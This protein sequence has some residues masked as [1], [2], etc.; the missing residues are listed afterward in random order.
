[1]KQ[2]AFLILL[3]FLILMP[4]GGFGFSKET[5]ETASGSPDLSKLSVLDLKTAGKIALS[6][7]PSL[8]AARSRVQQAKARLSQTRSAYWP[9]LDATA[10]YSRIDLSGRTYA[11]NLAFARIFDPAA[12]VDNPDDYYNAGLRATWVLFDGFERK[13]SNQAALYGKELSE[14]A[15]NDVKRLLL[16]SVAETYFAAQL[17]AE[18][19][20]I[21]QADKTFN[22]KLFE[23]AKA[24]RLLGS[25]S[26]SDEMNFEIRTNSAEIKLI[27]G[28]ITYKSIM[29][30]LAAVLGL[31]DATFPPHIQ[32]A[33]LEPKMSDQAEPVDTEGLIDFALQNRFDILRNDS[34]LKATESEV[35]IA[36]ARFY[37]TVNLSASVDGSRTGDASFEQDDFGNAAGL[38]ISYNLFSGGLDRAKLRETKEKRKETEKDLAA[39]KLDVISEVRRA[40]ENLYLAQK[41]LV[42]QKSTVVLVQKNRNLVEMEYSAGQSSLVRLNE[43]QRDLITAQSRL[44]LSI[45]SL[46]KANFDLYASTGR[47]LEKF[48]E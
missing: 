3:V 25:G 19:I 42:L 21:S 40:V 9:R 41:E 35:E 17:A 27:R 4:A 11:E 16:S 6:R 22:Q 46:R 30:G 32:L 18:S 43:A 7:N 24:R 31:P 12:T 15:S 23:E 26:L 8:A 14:F 38:S 5:N 2:T 10:S 45:V 44:A 29:Y 1:M 48:E 47:I 39:L 20:K 28:E 33:A 36:R 37:P 13:F 34:A